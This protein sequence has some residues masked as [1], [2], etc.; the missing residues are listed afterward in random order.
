M[1]NNKKTPEPVAAGSGADAVASQNPVNSIAQAGSKSKRNGAKSEFFRVKKVSDFTVISN[2][3]IRDAR[4]SYKARMILI[5]ML[6]VSDGFEITKQWLT[7]KSDKDGKSSVESGLKELQE[8]GYLTVSHQRDSSG[9]VANSLYTVYEDPQAPGTENQIQESPK[10][11]NPKQE[12]P[13]K[14]NR[15]QRNTNSI[16]KTNIPPISPKGDGTPEAKK[17][18]G[19]KPKQTGEEAWAILGE[20]ARGKSQSVRD[21][22]VSF[23][24]ACR[25]RNPKSGANPLTAPAAKMLVNKLDRLSRGNEAVM[26]AMLDEAIEHN[27]QTVYEH[28]RGN[29]SSVGTVPN[30]PAEELMGGFWDD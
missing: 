23:V 27:W 11:E 4:L 26:V 15:T 28:D 17:G 10:P 2:K 21:R 13:T 3:L 24:G 6:S 12:N 9:Y 30:A 1:S 20:W 29:A 8:Y 14:E 22:L 16:K 7:N 18:R 19:R 5:L 25:D